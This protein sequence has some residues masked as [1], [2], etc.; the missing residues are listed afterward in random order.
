MKVIDAAGD[1]EIGRMINIRLE[2][3]ENGPGD[4]YLGGAVPW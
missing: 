3:Y 4:R 1:K 2:G